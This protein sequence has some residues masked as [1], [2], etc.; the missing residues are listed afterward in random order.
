MKDM[1]RQEKIGFHKG[2]IVTLVNER[3]ELLKIVAI[4]ESL[5]KAHTEE[6]RKMGVK[7]GEKKNLEGQL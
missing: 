3:N 5:I 1:E 4:V 7:V 6:L 2:S